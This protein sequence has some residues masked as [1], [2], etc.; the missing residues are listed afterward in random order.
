MKLLQNTIIGL[1]YKHWTFLEAFAY[2]LKGAARELK[3]APDFFAQNY[4]K[5]VIRTFVNRW[6]N[7]N[8]QCFEIK[9][10][11]LPYTPNKPNVI[12]DL[13]ANIFEDTFTFLTYFDDKYDKELVERLDRHMK[14][15]SYCY[16][17]KSFDVTVKKGEVVIDAGAWIGDFS[18]YAVFKGAECY[19]FEP[20]KE[21][22]EILLETAHLN[23]DRIHPVQQGLGSSVCEMNIS[24]RGAGSS[25][26]FKEEYVGEEKI[27][28][29]TL[30]K[31]VEE[32]KLKRVDFIKADIEGAEREMLKGAINTLK[33]FAPK[34]A[35][36][37]YHLP[38]DPEVLEKLILE[39]NP[40]YQIVH[41]RH[42]LFAAVI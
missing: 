4:Q 12:S 35:I 2:F 20:L 23:K 18:A 41:L 14:D 19:A 3:I 36:C 37:T 22:Y 25:I 11:L 30:D 1:R 34:L 7:K 24:I 9:G 17:D 13:A 31:F 29:T 5:I 16:V 28:I 40:D 42:K 15:G 26:I 38:D 10:V 32:N 33:T 39:A 8:K 27:K 6:L 21:N